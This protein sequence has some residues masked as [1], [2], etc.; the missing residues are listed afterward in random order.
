MIK[1]SKNGDI[2]VWKTS[3]M[4]TLIYSL[5]QDVRSELSSSRTDD[6]TEAKKVKIKLLMTKV[7]GY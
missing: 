7:G 3:A 1:T 4:P 5:P 6:K 2:G